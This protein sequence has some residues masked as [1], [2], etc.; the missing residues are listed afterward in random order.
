MSARRTAWATGWVWLGWALASAAPAADAPATW[1]LGQCLRYGLEHGLSARQARLDVQVSEA[2]IDQAWAAVFPRV[3]TSARYTRLDRTETIEF[4]DMKQEIGTLDN[5]SA[6]VSVEQL[7]YSGGRVGAGLRAARLTREWASGNQEDAEARL[8]RDIR[9]AFHQVTLLR[10]SVDVRKATVGHLAALAAQAEARS[11]SGT[12][13]ELEALSAKVRLG[14][15]QPELL[16]A[17]NA[18][19]TAAAHFARLLGWEGAPLTLAGDGGEES[20][21]RPAGDYVAAA[22]RRRSSL[23][24]LDRIVRLREADVMATRSGTKPEVRLGATGSGANSQGFSSLSD[25]WQ[26]RWNAWLGVS[27]TL[28]DGGLTKASVKARRLE[29]EK[30]RL[31]LDEAVRLVKLEVRTAHDEARRAAQAVEAA[32]SNVALAERAMT[33]A[34]SRYEAGLATYLEVT[35]ANVALSAARLSCLAARR[36]LAVAAADLDYACGT[37]KDEILGR[38]R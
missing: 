2:T 38:L 34:Q 9:A 26:W 6:Q 28:W 31:T 5:Y 21:Q 1:T 32:L 10:E 25:D 24:S 13:S 37:S 33:I 15:E 8:I 22:V 30:A 27:W 11:R 23:A 12:G 4:G 14:N 3:E 20:P 16:R 19:A 7:A 35:D 29:V 18:V 36:D 17:S